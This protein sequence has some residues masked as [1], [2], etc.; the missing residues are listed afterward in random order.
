MAKISETK[1]RSDAK[2]GYARLFG[3]QQLGQLVSRVHAT[4]IRTG[5]EL[6]HI[7]E[8]ET[9]AHMRHSWG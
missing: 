7:I 6:E 5:N 2:S 8:S 4:V 1:G 3:S 9:P